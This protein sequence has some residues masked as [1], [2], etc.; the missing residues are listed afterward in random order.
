MMPA[1]P[2]QARDFQIELSFTSMQETAEQARRAYGL[3]EF[4]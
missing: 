2:N 3:L 1:P 4:A